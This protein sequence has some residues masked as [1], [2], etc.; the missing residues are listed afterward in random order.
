MKKKKLRLSFSGRRARSGWLF[1]LP[2][3]IGFFVFFFVP[4]LTLLVTLP[5]AIA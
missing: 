3:L 1:C 5:V 2:F 4:M